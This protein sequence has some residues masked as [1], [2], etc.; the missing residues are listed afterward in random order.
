MPFGLTNAP[1]TFQMLMECIL[2]G[3]TAE[4]CL[5]YMDDIIVFSATFEQHLERLRRVLEHLQVSGM[6]LKPSKCHFLQKE[7][8]YLHGTQSISCRDTGRPS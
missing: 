6:K 1:V 8:T 2:A 3:L 4:E 7:V 5:M